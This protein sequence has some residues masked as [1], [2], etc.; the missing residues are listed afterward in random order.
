MVKRAICCKTILFLMSPLLNRIGVF[1]QKGWK[2][3]IGLLL[4]TMLDSRAVTGVLILS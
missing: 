2:L 1:M 4:K 3:L